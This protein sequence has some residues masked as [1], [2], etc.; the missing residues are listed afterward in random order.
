V[1]MFRGSAK[2]LVGNVAAGPKGSQFARVALWAFRH[3]RTDA[4]K[5]AAKHIVLR[6]ALGVEGK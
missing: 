6:N 3:V 4:V 5:A 1:V 2:V